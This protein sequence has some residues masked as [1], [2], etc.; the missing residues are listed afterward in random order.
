L[1]SWLKSQF[2]TFNRQLHCTNDDDA[3]TQPHC[4]NVWNNADVGVVASIAQ[5]RR[6]KVVGGI[7][8]GDDH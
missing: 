6:Y 2:S 8:F 4:C 1:N 3:A 5:W 7:I